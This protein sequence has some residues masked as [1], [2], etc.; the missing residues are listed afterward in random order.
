MLNKVFLIGRLTRD[1]E[2]RF[3]PSGIQITS[4]TIAVNRVYKTKD[5]S[6]WKEET[7]FFDVESF[8]YLAERLGKQLNKGSQILVE[9]SL[10]QD[11][12]ETPSGEK[13]SKIKVVADKVNLLS[14]KTEKPSTAQEE[15]NIDFSDTEDLSS[16]ED[17]PF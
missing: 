17:V 8:G 6:D 15:P 16:D 4:F 10:R 1:P 7:Y 13:R 2:I 11:K 12:W 5:S 9:G 14:G 3:L